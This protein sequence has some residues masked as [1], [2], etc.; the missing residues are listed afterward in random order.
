MLESCENCGRRIGKLEEAYVY[1]NSPVCAECYGRL[2]SVSKT[3][4]ARAMARRES[5]GAIGIVVAA[6]IVVSAVGVGAWM[7]HQD[8]RPATDAEAAPA[9][10]SII[11]NKP[12]DDVASAKPSQPASVPIAI[13]EPA[14]RTPK[15][16]TPPPVR[17]D[18]PAYTQG[19]LLKEL[20]RM[21]ADFDAAFPTIPPDQLVGRK[22]I[23]G[24]NSAYE[25]H[26]NERFLDFGEFQNNPI[27]SDVAEKI[28]TLTSLDLK[29]PTRQATIQVDNSGKMYKVDVDTDPRVP[30]HLVLASEIDD[31]RRRW[32]GKSLWYRQDFLSKIVP[33]GEPRPD[34][35]NWDV[36]PYSKLLVLDVK[37]GDAWAPVMFILRAADGTTGHV[38]VSLG[39]TM[40]PRILRDSTPFYK[41]FFETDP[42]VMFPHPPE[43]WHKI[44][45]KRVSIGMNAE[46][47][48]LSWGDPRDV[49]TTVTADGREEQ[50]IYGK[51]DSYVYLANGLVTAIQ[52]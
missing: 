1:K 23:I 29:D 30:E 9:N 50:W 41:Y 34:V 14:A 27:Y 44:E 21:R 32:K 52:N 33:P 47:V 45:S 5:S 19:N 51:G 49:K 12:R 26:P 2:T 37:A 25:R 46:Q 15:R 48:L 18:P 16:V 13:P 17:Q 39:N 35:S 6:L 22:F 20:A 43:I 3:K 36:K 42:H 7:L 28:C 8:R 11:I 24:R 10:A 4:P 40:V 38:E 31:A